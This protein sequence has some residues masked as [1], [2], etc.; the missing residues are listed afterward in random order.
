MR[1]QRLQEFGCIN[2]GLFSVLFI[3]KEV[4]HHPILTNGTLHKESQLNY[5]VSETALLK[6]H[7]P[8]QCKVIP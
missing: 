1:W 5:T 7:Y 2:L 8:I 4:F 3:Q 6:P